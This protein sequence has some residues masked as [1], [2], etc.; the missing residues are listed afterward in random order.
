[1]RYPWLFSTAATVLVAVAVLVGLFG[2]F[3]FARRLVARGQ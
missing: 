3:W 2:A 1:V